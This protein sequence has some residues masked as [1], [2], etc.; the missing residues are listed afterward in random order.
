MTYS[1]PLLGVPGKFFKQTF[2]EIDCDSLFKSDSI[3]KS[4]DELEA[5]RQIPEELKYD[6]TMNGLMK[7]RELYFNQQYM[8]KDALQPVWEKDKVDKWVELA[9]EG[10]LEGR[11]FGKYTLD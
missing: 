11:P 8:N 1:I 9:R 6:F 2:A 3:D 4:H 10:K 5:P 7:I